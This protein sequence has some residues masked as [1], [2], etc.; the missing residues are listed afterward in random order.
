MTMRDQETIVQRT[1]TWNTKPL[2]V[3][4]LVPTALV[5][6]VALGIVYL[7]LRQ[8][9][10]DTFSFVEADG[11]F[12]YLLAL[13]FPILHVPMDLPAYRAQRILL[14]ALAS[15]FGP[16]APWAIIGINIF[17]LA[18][19][20]YALARI[21]RHYHV[22]TSLG[23]IF[24]LWVGALF[25]IEMN[26]T[27]V[28]AYALVLWGILFWEEDRPLLAA[29]LCGLAVLAKETTVLY[30]IAF[31]LS[32]KGWAWRERLRFGL[33]AL[34]P[35]LVWQFVLLLTFGDSGLL[36]ARTRGAPA[37]HLM[38][39]VGLLWADTKAQWAW[40]VQLAWVLLPALV[41]FAWGIVLLV[42]ERVPAVA[43]ALIANGLFVASLP[44]ASTDYL[45]HSMRI[46]LAVVVALAW[47]LARTR[48]PLLVFAVV[49]IGLVPLIFFRVEVFF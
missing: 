24:G 48:R 33:L 31:L 38:P 35:G 30:A 8:F 7:K 23:L 16:Y 39:L 47:A 18:A 49:G 4:P 28:L 17:A 2:T 32:Y 46:G 37:E 12:V 10:Y 43:W 3:S 1:L 5:L 13:S 15:A 27:E 26:L 41:A 40:V 9:G 45:A 20:T 21:A 34:G 14:S 25:V 19:G 22:P 44:P 6:C 29:L 42:R 36:A 11:T